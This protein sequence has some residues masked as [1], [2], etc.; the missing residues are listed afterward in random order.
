MASM[1]PYGSNYDRALRRAFDPF[2]SFFSD[3]FGTLALVNPS[4]GKGPRKFIKAGS[5]TY[6][7]PRT[8]GIL[9][10]G[11]SY[12]YK[13]TWLKIKLS[14]SGSIV[15]LSAASNTVQLCNAKKR[16]LSPARIVGDQYTMRT[17]KDVYFGVKGKTTY[18]LKLNGS[19]LRS[20]Q[21]NQYFDSLGYYKTTDRKSVV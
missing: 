21:L 12:T 17:L 4:A 18:Y 16:P 8:Q 1:I 10:Y 2:G 5:T 11:P 20:G 13:T 9:M 3:P 19:G 6:L 15:F 14:S 7:P